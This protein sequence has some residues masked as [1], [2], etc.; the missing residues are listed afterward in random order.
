MAEPGEVPWGLRPPLIFGPTEARRAKKKNL[1]T[2][3]PLLL[4]PDPYLSVWIT[5]SIP[6]SKGLDP[7]LI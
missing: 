2:A 5:G 7:P 1:E 6:L 4:P 3:S